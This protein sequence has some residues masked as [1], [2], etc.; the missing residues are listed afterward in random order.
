MMAGQKTP[1][2]VGA[3][4]TLGLSAWVDTFRGR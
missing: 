1:E 2:Q 4:V 3:E